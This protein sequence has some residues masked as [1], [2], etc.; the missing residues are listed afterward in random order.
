MKTHIC[1]KTVETNPLGD[2][3]TP[4]TVKIRKLVFCG[5]YGAAHEYSESSESI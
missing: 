3:G 2:S 1:P 4:F 5:L